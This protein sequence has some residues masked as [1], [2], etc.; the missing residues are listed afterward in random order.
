MRWY[1]RAVD[2]SA[3]AGSVV[4]VRFVFNEATSLNDNYTGWYVDNIAVSTDNDH[5]GLPNYLEDTTYYKV[6]SVSSERPTIP[7][8]GSPG[9]A[10]LTGMDRWGV[11]SAALNVTATSDRWSGLTFKLQS[12]KSPPCYVTIVGEYGGTGTLVADLSPCYSPS[13]WNAHQS[14]TLSVTDSNSNDNGQIIDFRLETYSRSDKNI[15]STA[16]DGIN[17]GEAV[18]NYYCSPVAADVDDDGMVNAYDPRPWIDDTPPALHDLQGQSGANGPDFS[19]GIIFALHPTS[20]SPTTATTTGQASVGASDTPTNTPTTVGGST[21]IQSVSLT[22]TFSD[23]SSASIPVQE[24]EAEGDPQYAATFQPTFAPVVAFTLQV[25]DSN[26]NLVKYTFDISQHGSSTGIDTAE[27]GV[28]VTG[29]GAT[30]DAANSLADVFQGSLGG[31]LLLPSMLIASTLFLP[32]AG[33][34]EDQWQPDLDITT[35]SGDLPAIDYHNDMN[36]WLGDTSLPDGSTVSLYTGTSQTGW[37]RIHAEWPNEWGTPTDLLNYLHGKSG[38]DEIRV[39]TSDTSAEIVIRDTSI[40]VAVLIVG[41]VIVDAEIFPTDVN[42]NTATSLTSSVLAELHEIMMQAAHGSGYWDQYPPIAPVTT[43]NPNDPATKP[44]SINMINAGPGGD[45][46]AHQEYQLLIPPSV[47]QS[48]MVFK[49]VDSAFKPNDANTTDN[50]I[51]WFSLDIV[52]TQRAKQDLEKTPGMTWYWGSQTPSCPSSG[53]T[54]RR[55]DTLQT[56]AAPASSNS[57]DFSKTYFTWLNSQYHDALAIHSFYDWTS[58]DD[59]GKDQVQTPIS[60]ANY[61]SLLEGAQQDFGSISGTYSAY[62]PTA[63]DFTISDASVYFEAAQATSQ[64]NQH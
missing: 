20:S 15:A 56:T 23:G 28:Y 1:P 62:M 37:A 50:A 29:A 58:P 43:K 63:V 21:S 45:T 57:Y 18:L 38:S 59:A 51:A 47:L 39:P 53:D 6:T 14:W 40:V 46:S 19:Q 41:K 44:V 54:R 52:Q 34:G 17:D 26:Q 27:A 33:G 13:D 35:P 49:N 16:Q 31:L 2:L 3:Y 32:T 25:V 7:N 10:H 42:L 64:F 11:V 24:Q 5:D 9:V 48:V 22:A 12:D 55:C 8:D 61:E 60:Y 36:T 30:A 4:R